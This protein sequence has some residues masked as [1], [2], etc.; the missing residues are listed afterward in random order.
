MEAT[1][2]TKPQ[3]RTLHVVLAAVALVLLLAVATRIVRGQ[4]VRT[5]AT[6]EQL[7]SLVSYCELPSS[8]GLQYVVL[9]KTEAA[10]TVRIGLVVPLTCKLK[11]IKRPDDPALAQQ[12]L[13]VLEAMTS[14]HQI[15][16]ARV[17]REK[18]GRTRVELYDAEGYSLA[19]RLEQ[20]GHT[21]RSDD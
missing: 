5:Q 16:R 2:L 8:D 11:G 12:A 9:L 15:L 7:P 4:D 19:K 17:Y 21:P 1:H 13:K 20:G 10:D 14:T 6:P 3:R 18:D